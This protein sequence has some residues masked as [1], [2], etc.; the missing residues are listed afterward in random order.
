MQLHTQGQEAASSLLRRRRLPYWP[1]TT[2]AVNAGSRRILYI[3]N[4]CVVG[5]SS[6]P[7]PRLNRRFGTL[8][9]LKLGSP[10][11]F[12]AQRNCEEEKVRRGTPLPEAFAVAREDARDAAFRFPDNWC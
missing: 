7:S 8:T 6:S 1:A 11:S 10:Y 2:A 12:C 9:T 3:V 5:A 4:A